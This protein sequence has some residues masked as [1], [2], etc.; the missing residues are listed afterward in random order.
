MNIDS[1][2]NPVVFPNPAPMDHPPT[3]I[4]EP[5]NVV[6]DDNSP[7]PVPHVPS[8]GVKPRRSIRLITRPFSNKPH[9]SSSNKCHYL[10]S[11]YMSNAGLSGT[12][13]TF[14]TKLTSLKEPLNYDNATMDPKWILAMDQELQALQN[15]NTWS[16][17]DLPPHKV[18]I[19][20]KWVYKIK[21]NVNGDVYIYKSKVG[22]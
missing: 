13:Q 3:D 20:C 5:L 9:T 10:M 2:P 21:Y 1:C 4:V 12:Y 17:I 18:P 8:I 22:I 15:N 14:F 7:A 19:G 11:N 6:L 16:L